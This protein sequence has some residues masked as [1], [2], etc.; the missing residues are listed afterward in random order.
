MKKVLFLFSIVALFLIT[1]CSSRVSKKQLFGNALGTTY[2]IQYFSDVHEITIQKGLDSIFEAVNSSMSTYRSDSDISKI[3]RGD[4]TIR[5]DEMF[6]EVFEISKRVHRISEG[7]FDPTIG[8]LVNAWGFGAGKPLDQV[9]STTIDSIKQYI[10]FDKVHLNPNYTIDKESPDIYLEFN[11]V[12]KGYCID[13]IGTYLN[14]KNIDNYL[15]ELGGE[16]LAK[17]MHLEKKDSW[18]VGIDDPQQGEQRELSGIVQL[19]DQGMATSGNYRKFRVDTVTGKKYV[20]IVDPKSGYTRESRILSASVLAPTCAMA[21]AYAT[22]FMV[23]PLEK[24][25]SIVQKDRDLEVYLIYLDD[26]DTTRTYASENFKV[27]PA[28]TN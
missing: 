17:G 12:A 16:L 7:S 14:K 5:V 19:K 11:A 21:D 4:S 15:V 20:H 28:Y 3:N 26:N 6:R 13:R 10:G 23:L 25:K 9:D 27:Q 8:T 1:A 2:T 22:T 24:A 18:T